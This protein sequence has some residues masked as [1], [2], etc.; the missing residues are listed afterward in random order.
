MTKNNILNVLFHA[1]FVETTKKANLSNVWALGV[2][3]VSAVDRNLIHSADH[4]NPL[5]CQIQ[6]KVQVEVFLIIIVD[7]YTANY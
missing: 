7:N 3:D 5:N 4:S 6:V 2:P 1:Q